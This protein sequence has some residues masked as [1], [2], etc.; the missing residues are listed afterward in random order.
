MDIT[1]IS[2][3]QHSCYLLSRIICDD[4]I[5]IAVY[6]SYDDLMFMHPY[7]KFALVGGT[8]FPYQCVIDEHIDNHHY[9]ELYATVDGVD[10]D[11][12]IKKIDCYV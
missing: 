7:I 2:A 3:K 8:E 10:Y 6:Q 11:F 12:Q 4:V 9:I 5:P 1:N